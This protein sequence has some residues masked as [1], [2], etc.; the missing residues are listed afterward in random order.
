MAAPITALAGKVGKI[1]VNS[2]TVKLASWE[3]RVNNEVIKYATLSQTADSDSQYWKNT[4]SG[5]NEAT[6]SV[7]GYW[8]SNA[9]ANAKLT[10]STIGLRPGTGGA[11]TGFFGFTTSDGF[12]ATFVV[13]SITA[14]IDAEG[15]KPGMFEAT[16]AV[17]GAI[18]WPT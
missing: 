6:I 18:T 12:T 10:G 14:S 17:D 13:E 9:T 11:G 5:I 2:V 4:L 8:D 1:T 16:L 15:N 3:V 7:R